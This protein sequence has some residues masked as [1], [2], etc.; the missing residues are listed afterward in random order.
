MRGPQLCEAV[1][2]IGKALGAT[3]VAE[4]VETRE[5]LAL[6]SAMGCDEIQGFLVA[7]AVPAAQA[8]GMLAHPH[9][10]DV[11][12]AGDAHAASAAG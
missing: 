12:I 4:G 8:A 5:Q 7:P 11:G 10:I 3:V 6:L 9:L 1:I 2:S